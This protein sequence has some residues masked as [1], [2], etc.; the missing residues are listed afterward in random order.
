MAAEDSKE[1]ERDEAKA[2][3]VVMFQFLE[4]YLIRHA[5]LWMFATVLRVSVVA[6]WRSSGLFLDLQ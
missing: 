3:S 5:M 2:G 6:N 4:I 1:R